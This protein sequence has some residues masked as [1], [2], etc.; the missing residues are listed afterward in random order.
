MFIQKEIRMYVLEG[1][2]G[3]GKGTQIDLL[4][5]KF[6]DAVFLKYPTRDFQVLNDYLEKKVELNPKALFLL[7]LSDIA[8]G[9]EKIRR[10]EEEGRMVIL[11]RYV[12]S[13]IAYEL[14]SVDYGQAKKIIESINFIKPQK[15][16]LLDISPEESQKRKKAQKELD[17]YESDMKYL[18]K[19]RSNFLK[20]Y[21]ERFLCGNWVK[22]DA[23]K[24]V[25]A[26]YEDILGALDK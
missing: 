26:V 7:F 4:R 5:K 12:F 22:V 20:L 14:D 19:V 11:D 23:S 18:G 1:S 13:T 8:N 3:T 24:S 6:P 9:Q 21:E 17:R 2:D 10:A 15:V 25:D 16:I